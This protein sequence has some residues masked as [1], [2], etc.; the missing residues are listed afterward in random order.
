MIYTQS[1][2]IIIIGDCVVAPHHFVH[3]VYV[4]KSQ[5]DK[6]L[7]IGVTEDLKRR[8]AEHQ[9]GENRSTKHRRPFTLVYYEAFRA[10]VDAHERERKLKQFKNSYKHL[11]DR[12]GKCIDS[13]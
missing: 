4:L 13:A 12:I 5:K 10:K 11:K 9:N 7:Y 2:V 3:Y 1:N 6:K 8:F